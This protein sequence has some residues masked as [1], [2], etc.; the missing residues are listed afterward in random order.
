MT[1]TTSI[2]STI[3]ASNVTARLHCAHSTHLFSHPLCEEQSPLKRVANLAFHILTLG[4]PLATYHG[5]S[6][7]YP[8]RPFEQENGNLQSI[9]VISI[10]Q[11]KS[12]KSY[13]TLGQ[14]ALKFARIE[15][16]K[17]PEITPTQFSAGWNDPS[18]TNQ[19]I[20]QEIARLTT[21]FWDIGENFEK[22]IKKNR[23]NPWSNQE[24]INTADTLM[25]IGYAISN[26]TLD[27]LESFTE[28]L[29][30][31][32]E[33]RTFANALTAQD[34]YQYRTFFFCTTTYHWL[35]GAISW[36]P[37]DQGDELYFCETVPESHAALFYQQG[38]IQHSWN[39]LYND[40]CNRVRSYVNE[41]ELMKADGRHIAWTK[42]DAGVITFRSFPCPQPT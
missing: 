18:T 28:M 32:G 30:S 37:Y 24:V 39:T 33:N 27:D 23:E 16:K 13:S 36:D 3:V 2:P 21:L 41:E 1:Y 29:S 7:C 35:R 31:K 34:S 19:P 5:I 10:Q 22:L 40:Y 17:H 9:G 25:K 6:C 42:P 26:M 4:I 14:E 8:R 12:I 38:T 20:N 15:L 11:N